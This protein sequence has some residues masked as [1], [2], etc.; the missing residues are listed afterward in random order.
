MST[1][2][3]TKE[4]VNF[5]QR[6][7][8]MM[9]R[10]MTLL[11]A[12]ILFTASVFA[13]QLPLSQQ[14]SNLYPEVGEAVSITS[15]FDN[16]AMQMI[17]EV[18]YPEGWTIGEEISVELGPNQA[19]FDYTYELIPNGNDYSFIIVLEFYGDEEEM[20]NSGDV[21]VTNIIFIDDISQEH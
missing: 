18:P 21:E 20:K 2:N 9:A 12:G 14:F 19:G 10:V 4:R 15:T 13:Q 6:A 11:I 8:K 5:I 1:M 16:P 7:R 17:L 3:Q